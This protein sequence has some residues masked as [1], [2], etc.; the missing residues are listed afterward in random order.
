LSLFS[1]LL[2]S[3]LLFSSLILSYLI[4]PLSL[5]LKFSLDGSA[6]LIESLTTETVLRRALQ[7]ALERVVVPAPLMKGLRKR[8][9]EKEREKRRGERKETVEERNK[10]KQQDERGRYTQRSRD[11]EGET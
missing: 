6:K 4:L 11:S 9:G 8:D 5:T 10:G 3:S 7:N 1:S 2:F